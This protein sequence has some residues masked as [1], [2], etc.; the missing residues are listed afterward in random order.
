LLSANIL[1]MTIKDLQ[2]QLRNHIRARMHRGEWTGS[3]LSRQAGFQQGHLSNFLN[4]RRGLSVEA[5]DRLLEILDI[6]VLDLLGADDIE[7]RVMLPGPAAKVENIAMV[8][9][10]NAV[11]ARFSANQILETHSFRRSFLRKL[12]PNDAGGRIDWLRFVL[13]KLDARSVGGALPLEISQV[14]LLI[15]RHYSSLRPYRRSRPNLYALCLQQRCFLGY[16]SLAGDQVVLRPHD[17]RAAVEVVRIERGRS[18]S[19]YIVGRV[20]YVGAEM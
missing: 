10:E 14:T 3:S 11:L 18:Y 5:M 9:A 15:D 2:D 13:I 12:K 19:E 6:G 20:C 8:S 16:V 4:G 1:T 7:R 17:P